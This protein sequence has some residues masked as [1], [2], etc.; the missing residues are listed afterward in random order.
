MEDGRTEA[1]AVILY[2]GGSVVPFCLSTQNAR[3]HM[4][5]LAF[6]CPIYGDYNV[7][8]KHTYTEPSHTSSS[9]SS[10]GWLW[11]IS[12]AYCACVRIADKWEPV[13]GNTYKHG[14]KHWR[15]SLS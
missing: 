7:V 15:N 5:P 9:Y 8:H 6:R 3:P 14:D 10:A 2:V 13:Y 1:A 4:Q 11:E 12:F